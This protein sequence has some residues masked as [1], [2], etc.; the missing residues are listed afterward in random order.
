MALVE[1]LKLSTM[2]F[3]QCHGTTSKL[4]ASLALYKNGVCDNFQ[5]ILRL[6]MYDKWL[7]I[8]FRLCRLWPTHT[9]EFSFNLGFMQNQKESVAMHAKHV[10]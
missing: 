5:S 8:F 6:I 4:A 9:R 1:F 3:I 7:H 2:L 10:L